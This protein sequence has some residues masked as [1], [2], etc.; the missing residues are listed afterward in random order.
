MEIDDFGY[1]DAEDES[2]QLQNVQLKKLWIDLKPK[3]DQIYAE[4]DVVDWKF[5][6]SCYDLVFN[7][8]MYVNRENIEKRIRGHQEIFPGKSHE[9]ARDLHNAVI[10][11]MGLKTKDLSQAS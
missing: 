10:S 8:L 11:Y 7:Y 9:F 3:L 6:S 5:M 1:H 2:D 4:D